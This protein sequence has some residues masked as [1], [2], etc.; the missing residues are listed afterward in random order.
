[1]SLHPYSPT[2][3]PPSL[4]PSIPRITL[5]H[6]LTGGDP[7]ASASH[8]RQHKWGL[9]CHWVCLQYSGS[10]EVRMVEGGVR[11]WEG[12]G[13]DRV[14][15]GGSMSLV[16]RLQLFCWHGEEQPWHYDIVDSQKYTHTHTVHCGMLTPT[17]C[18]L[19]HSGERNRITDLVTAF[20]GSVNAI[21]SVLDICK[22]KSH[23]WCWC[24]SALMC[25]STPSNNL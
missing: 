9:C 5:L 14:L 22:T 18:Q 8:L 10:Q 11:R 2:V 17:P 6:L 20:R 19:Q 21:F 15:G 16:T 1:M 4:L 24:Q 13:A 3:P 7:Y 23:C 25:L 12:L